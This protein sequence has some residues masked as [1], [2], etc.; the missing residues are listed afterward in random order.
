[1]YIAHVM[2]NLAKYSCLIPSLLNTRETRYSTNNNNSSKVAKWSSC[3]V[4]DVCVESISPFKT[5]L[6]CLERTFPRISTSSGGN[7][8]SLNEK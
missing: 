7:E 1:M 3:T 6:V 5:R 2:V 4:S 8:R